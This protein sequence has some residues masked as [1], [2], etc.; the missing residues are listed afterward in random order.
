MT[1]VYY[2]GFTNRESADLLGLSVEA[3]ESLL[4]RARRA[5]SASLFPLRNELME[6]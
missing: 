2:Q 6:R 5:L 4:S 3:V 1:L